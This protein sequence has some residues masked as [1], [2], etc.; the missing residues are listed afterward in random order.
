MVIRRIRDADGSWWYELNVSLW[1][2]VATHHRSTDRIAGEPAPTVFLAPAAVVTPIKGQDYRGVAIWRHPATLRR[3][4][5]NPLQRPRPDG[6]PVPWE[7]DYPGVDN[8]FG[9]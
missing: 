9:A 1:A 4:H 7:D 6:R 8:D 5:R 3:A 2:R